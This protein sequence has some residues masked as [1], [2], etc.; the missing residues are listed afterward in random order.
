MCDRSGAAYTGWKGWIELPA[1]S[2]PDGVGDWIDLSHALNERM[3][4]PAFFPA[5]RFRRVMSQPEQPLN[6]TQMQMVVHLGTHVDA[7]RHFFSDGPTFDQI[8]LDRLVG[9]GVVWRIDK[10]EHDVIDVADLEKA[11]PRARPGDI[12]ALDTGWSK[13]FESHKYEQHPSLS[14]AAARWLVALRIKLLAVDFNTPDL[15]INRRPEGFDWPVHHALLG[16][17]VLISEHLRNLESLAGGRAEFVFGA[18]NIE[19]SDG[20]PARVLARRAA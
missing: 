18:L 13:H 14:V 11:H 2:P 17:G 1:A 12:V 8:P 15:A 6:V 3:P 5:P 19:N 4:R 20:A 9:G 10:S 16:H 7:P